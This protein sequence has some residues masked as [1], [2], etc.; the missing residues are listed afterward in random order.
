MILKKN[1]YVVNYIDTRQVES[2]AYVFDQTIDDE[3]LEEIIASYTKWIET[4]TDQLASD[5]LEQL[6][7]QHEQ[8]DD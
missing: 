7:N 8:F 5:Q 3:L 1:C 6:E 2:D 4:D